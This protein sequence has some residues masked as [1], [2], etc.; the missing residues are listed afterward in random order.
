MGHWVMAADHGRAGM[1]LV[2]L[3]EEEDVE[4]QRVVGNRDFCMN[5]MIFIFLCWNLLYL[6]RSIMSLVSEGG[7]NKQFILQPFLFAVRESACSCDFVD[8]I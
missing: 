7:V 2:R 5:C 8:I 6:V 3:E 4:D 1:E